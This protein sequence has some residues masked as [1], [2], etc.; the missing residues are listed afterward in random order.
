M[1]G[2]MSHEGES[3]VGNRLGGWDGGG[4]GQPDGVISLPVRRHPGLIT[5]LILPVKGRYA[6]S[7]DGQAAGDCASFAGRRNTN[8][9]GGS[10]IRTGGFG[11]PPR[12]GLLGGFGTQ[13]RNPGLTVRRLAWSQLTVNTSCALLPPFSSSLREVLVCRGRPILG[14]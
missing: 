12:F 7:L 3:W 5:A 11:L 10:D 6:S 2:E 4:T 8:G 9:L 1:S 13:L 14:V